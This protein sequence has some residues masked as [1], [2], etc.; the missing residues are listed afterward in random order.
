M[1]YALVILV[2][3][4]IRE[5]G[6]HQDLDVA[7]DLA[8]KAFQSYTGCGSRVILWDLTG[9]KAV[10]DESRESGKIP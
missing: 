9:K 7:V 1:R 6:L 5:L 3:E 8:R 10:S 4:E 2:D